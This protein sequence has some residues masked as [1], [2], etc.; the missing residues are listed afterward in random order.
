MNLTKKQLV[1]GF[2]AY[3]RTVSVEINVSINFNLMSNQID[4]SLQNLKSDL[5]QSKA[6]LSAERVKSFCCFEDFE[7]TIFCIL[8]SV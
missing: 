4:F 2:M 5:A 3:K 8:F 6:L 7:D 1:K